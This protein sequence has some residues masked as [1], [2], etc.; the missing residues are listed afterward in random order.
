[1]QFSQKSARVAGLCITGDKIYQGEGMPL[2][3]WEQF[4]SEVSLSFLKTL[5]LKS[6][7]AKLIDHELQK[8]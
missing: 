1:M 5:N 2:N 7:R 8:M 4:S 3:L 6:M